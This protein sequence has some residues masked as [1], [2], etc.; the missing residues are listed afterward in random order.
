MPPAAQVRFTFVISNLREGDF[1][2]HDPHFATPAG[3]ELQQ[4]CNKLQQSCNLREGDFV[5]DDPHFA[6]PAGSVLQQSCNRAATESGSA[7]V[8]FSCCLTAAALTERRVCLR[9]SLPPSYT[10]RFRPHTLLASALIH[11]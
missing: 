7:E 3:S 5:A 1:V 2:A 10:T 11:Y 8:V 4:S 9:Y 6:T